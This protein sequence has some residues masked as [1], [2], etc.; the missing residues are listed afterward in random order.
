[1]AKVSFKEVTKK[2]GSTELLK[3][4]NL[5]VKDQEFLVLV[6]PSGCGKSTTLRLLAGLETL[7]NG[8]IYIGDR[9]VNRLDPKDR[10]IA[11]V[12][13]NY[14]LYPHY[15]VFEN[16]A[17]SLRLRKVP[18]AEI[19]QRVNAI[20]Q[21]LEIEMLLERKPKELSGGQRQ[22]VA[23]GRAII[24]NPKVFL[25]DEPL[26]NLDA[27]LRVAMRAELMSL[28][29]K[30]KTTTIYVTHDQV[31][32]MTMGDRIVVL[33]EGKIQQ[34]GTPH[35]IYHEP[36]NRFVAG[37]M[38]SPPM[39]FLERGAITLGVRP[40]DIYFSR[41]EGENWQVPATFQMIEPLG[42]EYLFHVV[43]DGTKW[44]IRSS[45]AQSFTVGQQVT[46]YIPLSKIYF[47]DEE[48]E[49]ARIPQEL[50]KMSFPRRWESIKKAA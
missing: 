1:M 15:T 46:L 10:D 31:E 48:K 25:M 24:R 9:L 49:G 18:K 23:L 43:V 37:F 20:A 16:L 17:F 32:A 35:E 6:G 14:A 40:E 41:P 30:L 45:Q 5:E 26:S 2:F 44:I 3:N 12:F 29:R 50:S 42:A 33:N 38:G 11:M 19:Q 39:N 28:Q 4:F 22:R 47:F 7:N 27:K 36:A 13:Q 34:V 21:M 8:E